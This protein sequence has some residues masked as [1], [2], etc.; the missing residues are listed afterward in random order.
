MTHSS[1]IRIQISKPTT[2]D[3]QEDAGRGNGELVD[4]VF[5]LFSLNPL[6]LSTIF[7]KTFSSVL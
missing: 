1:R 6:S 7:S 3:R 5:D 2:H 4:A